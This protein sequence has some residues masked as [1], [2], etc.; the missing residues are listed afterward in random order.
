LFLGRLGFLTHQKYALVSVNMP[1]RRENSWIVKQIG[2]RFNIYSCKS[3]TNIKQVA[4]WNVE[5]CFR[6]SIK[7][8]IIVSPFISIHAIE[9]PNW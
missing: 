4:C 1:F 6:F 2:V 5:T 7:W 8:S 3:V 9:R